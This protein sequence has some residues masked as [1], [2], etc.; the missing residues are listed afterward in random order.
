MTCETHDRNDGEHEPR[1]GVVRS[2][3]FAGV[4][5]GILAVVG[6]LAGFGAIASGLTIGLLIVLLL[7]PWVRS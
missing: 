1:R 5:M 6:G 2:F 3:L 4:V 7:V